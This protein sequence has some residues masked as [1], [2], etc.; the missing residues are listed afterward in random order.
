MK[1]IILCLLTLIL[2]TQICIADE[3]R[4]DKEIK[5]QKQI[6]QIGYRILN[7]NKID[8][9][10]T[11]YYVPQKEVKS[12]TDLGKKKVEIS[13]G[14]LPFVDS[15]DELA[16]I[17]CH[18]ITYGTEAHKGLLRRIGMKT[19]PKKFELR[20]D[21]NA[22]DLMVN[23]GY[24]PIA[25]I[26]ILNKITDEPNWFEGYFSQQS[27]KKRL[28]AIYDYVYNKYPEYLIENDYKKNIYYQNFLLTTKTERKKIREKYI[29]K[30]TLP[31]DNKSKK[32]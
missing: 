9:R 10:I 6:M 12:K 23:A 28:L 24:N 2:C 22:V 11:F 19:A 29:E 16:A 27:G 3:L 26:I 5:Y 15:D 30:N 13:K 7:A 25:L 1:N 21:K 17:L 32:S 4:L 31:V 20:A 8:K 14:L 18:E